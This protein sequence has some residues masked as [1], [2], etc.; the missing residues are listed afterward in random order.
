MSAERR[1]G[2]VRG[3]MTPRAALTAA[4]ECAHYNLMTKKYIG[5]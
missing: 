5:L 4:P 1:L 3:H 2:L